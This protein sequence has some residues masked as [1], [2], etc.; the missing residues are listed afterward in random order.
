MTGLTIAK[1]KEEKIMSGKVPNL[2]LYRY[3]LTS[4]VKKEI[5][6][7]I[8]NDSPYSPNE[9]LQILVGIQ[10]SLRGMG[11][12]VAEISDGRLLSLRRV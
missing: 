7:G 4:G 3:E 10:T 5:V 6:S 2:F 11:Y 1:F 9:V 8:V 12:N